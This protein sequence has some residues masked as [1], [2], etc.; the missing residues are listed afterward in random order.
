MLD[1][2]DVMLGHGRITIEQQQEL[3]QLA[4]DHAKP[5]ASLDVMQALANLNERVSR[6]EKGGTVNPPTPGKYP[7][8]VDGMP[9][10][11]GQRYMWKGEAYECTLPEYVKVCTFSPA[12]YPSYWRKL[13]P[14]EIKLSKEVLP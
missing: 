11:N 2:I 14:E 13:T 5:E 7:E 8:Y 10:K 1:R 4:R 9:A 3:A 6:L 12:R